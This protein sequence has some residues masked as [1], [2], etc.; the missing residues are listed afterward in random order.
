M[1]PRPLDPQVGAARPGL[2]AGFDTG[3]KIGVTAAPPRTPPPPHR[4]EA[5]S[6]VVYFLDL[7]DVTHMLAA[8]H[9]GPQRAKKVLMHAELGS[10][11]VV[12]SHAVPASWF[13]A[14]A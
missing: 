3:V 4:L 10:G 8:L 1:N 9:G 12:S 7:A 6:Q 2:F 11:R 5:E 13:R 14:P